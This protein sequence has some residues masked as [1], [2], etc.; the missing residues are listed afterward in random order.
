[1]TAS[2]T[3]NNAPRAKWWARLL[4]S[5]GTAT[6]LAAAVAATTAPAQNG[7]YRSAATA[8][9]AWQT[10]A[11][12]LKT[13]FEQRL[14]A[15]DEAARRVQ[16]SVAKR[17]QQSADMLVVRAWVLPSGKIERLEFDGIDDADLGV[18][19]RALL[20]SVTVTS[21]PQDMLQPL[22]LRVSLHASAQSRKEQ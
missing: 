19:L 9:V 6:S 13:R 10:F 17:E 11:R 12:E 8:P 1:M 16:E 20:A 5:T 4:R 15:D 3:T 18:S 2:G 21:P 14:G 22:H 7:E